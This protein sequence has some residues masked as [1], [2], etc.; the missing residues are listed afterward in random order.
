MMTRRIRGLVASAVFLLAAASCSPEH[1]SGPETG[2]L[3][4]A[5]AGQGSLGNQYQLSN[6]TFTITG[7]TTLTISGDPNPVTQ[8]LPVGVYTITLVPGWTMSRVNGM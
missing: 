8:S 1:E 6:A 3:E 7:Q 2:S 4:L 5:L